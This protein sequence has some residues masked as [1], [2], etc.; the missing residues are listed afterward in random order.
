MAGLLQGRGLVQPLL[1]AHFCLLQFRRSNYRVVRRCQ[2][3]WYLRERLFHARPAC[4]AGV[5]VQSSPSLSSQAHNLGKMSWEG[6]D[7]GCGTLREDD[8]GSS[9]T[10]CGWVHRQRNLGGE[11]RHSAFTMLLAQLQ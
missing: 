2:S 11:F 6:R 3:A 4:A 7:R 8:V 1:K 5:D 9:L 10:L